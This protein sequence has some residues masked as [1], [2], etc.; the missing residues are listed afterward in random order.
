[1][2][3][4]HHNTGEWVRP[5]DWSTAQRYPSDAYVREY[6]SIEE[7]DNAFVRQTFTWMLE[8][9]EVVTQCGSDVFQIR[10]GESK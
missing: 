6:A 3:F 8:I 5:N 2:M 7:I 4:V 9:G 1:M 10:Q